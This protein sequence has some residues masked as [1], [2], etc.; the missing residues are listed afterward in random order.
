MKG[1][2]V[3]LEHTKDIETAKEIAM[4]HLAEDPEYYEKLSQVHK[5]AIHIGPKGESGKE[6]KDLQQIWSRVW[7]G[8]Q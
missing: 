2:H 4:D 7:K 5:E 8:R 3:E 6:K 1:I